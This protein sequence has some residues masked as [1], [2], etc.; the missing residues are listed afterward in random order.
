MKK[1][2]LVIG[3]LFLFSMFLV[4]TVPFVVAQDGV[5]DEELGNQDDSVVTDV[6]TDSQEENVKDGN[7][8]TEC[9]DFWMSA[10]PSCPGHW[11]AGGEYPDDCTCDWVCDEDEKSNSEVPEG[12]EECRDE[13]KDK[14]DNEEERSKCISGCKSD[15]GFVDVDDDYR[16]EDMSQEDCELTDECEGIFGPSHCEGDVCTTDM[17]WKG[18]RYEGDE[19]FEEYEEEELKVGAGITPDSPFYFLDGLFEGCNINNKEEKIA[20]IKQMVEEDKIDDAKKALKKYTDCAD[21]LEKEINPERR[22]EAKRSA[23]AI[24][25]VMKN[26]RNQLPEGERGKFVSDIMSKEHKIATAAEIAGKIEELCSE[27]S[28]LDPSRYE[29]TC[30]TG[31]DAPEW[32][33]KKHK[34]WTEEQRKEA[35]EFGS[36]MKA[37]FRTSGKECRCEDISFYDFSVACEKASAFAVECDDGVEESCI[38]LDEIEMPELPEHLQDVFDEVEAKEA[39]YENHMPYECVEAG[40]TTPKECTKVMIEIGAPEECKQA[41]LDSGCESEREC[42]KICDDIMFELHSPQECID[43]GITDPKECGKFM[44]N[45]RGD[46]HFGPMEGSGDF[47]GPDCMSIKDPMERLECYDNKGNEVGE[48]Y[49]PKEGPGVEGE[50]TWQC[51]EHRIHWPPDCE[52]FM[53]DELPK[54]QKEARGE[55]TEEIRKR[56][57]EC[58]QKCESQGKPWDFTGGNC[59]CGEPGQYHNKERGFYDES[60]CKDGCHQECPGADETSCNEEEKCVCI[61]RDKEEGDYYN[62]ERGSYSESECKDGCH[63]ECGDQNTDCVNDKCVCLGGGGDY[64]QE[65]SDAESASQQQ[66]SDEG[67]AAQQEASDAESASQQAESDSGS[68]DGGDDGGDSNVGVTGNAFLEYYH[69]R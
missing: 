32:Q 56:E 42:R 28:L 24:R 57:R 39:Q 63:Q 38:A 12:L 36:I 58:A 68:S 44:D 10:T 66:S 3:I 1:R 54:L 22:E 62:P 34:E 4:L 19:F 2:V 35:A 33:K 37:C 60:E 17:V 41:L 51:K 18:C 49:G 6:Q 40:A 69:S 29:D 50:I 31:D 23:A 26:I 67:S 9:N 53:R 46:E 43:E 61:Y 25:E 27:L 16:C 64:S 11:E 20:E 48:Y 45:F 7:C 52:K 65:S 14:F 5:V 55:R 47:R 15:F 8:D 21:E 30:K 13:C 59:Q